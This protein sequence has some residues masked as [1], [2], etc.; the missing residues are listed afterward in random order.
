MVRTKATAE[1]SNR[2]AWLCWD[3]DG[4]ASGMSSHGVPQVQVTL[5]GRIHLAL[6]IM[7]DD[8]LVSVLSVILISALEFAV[9]AI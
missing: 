4:S 6:L 8:G 1:R 3:G 7:V 9:L 2:C 5:G